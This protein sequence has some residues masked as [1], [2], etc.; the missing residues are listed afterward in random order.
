VDVAVTAAS[1]LSSSP[2]HCVPLLEIYL[3]L[4]S[5]FPVGA[6]SRRHHTRTRETI[7]LEHNRVL[8]GSFCMRAPDV[9]YQPRTLPPTYLD[10]AAHGYPSVSSRIAPVGLG[11]RRSA[12][13]TRRTMTP[14]RRSSLDWTAD[15]GPYR[16][17]QSGHG[18]AGLARQAIKHRLPCAAS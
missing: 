5:I 16:F 12:S 17:G 11:F 8:V 7:G 3:T 4:S 18:L 10:L 9:V 15:V 13:V 2:H 1:L 6:H 14:D